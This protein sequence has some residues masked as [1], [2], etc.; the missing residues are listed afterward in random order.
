M[1]ILKEEIVSISATSSH[2]SSNLNSNGDRRNIFS[3][4]NEH[5]ELEKLP[6]DILFEIL[7]FLHFLDLLKLG[8]VNKYFNSICNSEILWKNVCQNELKLDFFSWKDFA[9]W[10]Y[11]PKY[12]VC[13]AR[14]CSSLLEDG[15]CKVFGISRTSN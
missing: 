15:V 3:L 14:Q 9:R 11:F 13:G 12:D 5:F 7:K 1:E 10:L 2:S 6:K 4:K 8:T